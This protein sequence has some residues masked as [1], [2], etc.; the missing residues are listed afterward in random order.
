[1]LPWRPGGRYPLRRA[2]GSPANE[3]WR[4]IMLRN[5]CWVPFV[6]LL[7][8]AG[9]ATAQG[10]LDLLPSDAIASCAVRNLND[11]KK[12]GDKF[13]KDVDLQI[14]VRLSQLFDMAS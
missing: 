4:Y 14:P 5:A 6:A 2:G 13:I 3:P 9:G 10:T 11:L 1:M 12:K 7:A 8:T